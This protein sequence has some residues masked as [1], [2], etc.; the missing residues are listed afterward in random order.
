[1]FYNF[2]C[3]KTSFLFKDK[4]PFYDDPKA[5]FHIGSVK[6]WLQSISYMVGPKHL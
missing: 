4:D 5:D 3:N 1:M 6:M 2:L